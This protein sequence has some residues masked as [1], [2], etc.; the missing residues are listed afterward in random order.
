MVCATKIVDARVTV[1]TP[2]GVDF[3]YVIAGPGKRGT[4]YAFDFVLRA[5]MVA[6]AAILG[7]LLGFSLVYSRWRHPG[8][9]VDRMVCHNL[10]VRSAV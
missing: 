1:E 9:A 6:I 7:F 2:E 8:P 10:A 3:Q 4:A 5:G